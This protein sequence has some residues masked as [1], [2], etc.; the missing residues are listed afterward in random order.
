MHSHPLLTWGKGTE[1]GVPQG[2]HA[3]RAPRDTCVHHQVLSWTPAATGRSESQ[4]WDPCL[5]PRGETPV[6]AVGLRGWRMGLR[7]PGWAAWPAP[8]PPTPAWICCCPGWLPWWLRRCSVCLQCRRPG[9]DPWV[10]KIPWRRKW[11]PTPVLLPGTS[12]GQRSLV[13]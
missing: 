8:T 3:S 9:F 11:Q 12:H 1:P 6:S 7:S 5:W 2:G 4:P 10:G 13:G